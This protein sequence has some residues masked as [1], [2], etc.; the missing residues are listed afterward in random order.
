MMNENVK[1]LISSFGKGLPPQDVKVGTICNYQEGI[2]KAIVEIMENKVEDNY[3][4]IKIKVLESKYMKKDNIFDI[5]VKIGYENLM[6]IWRLTSIGNYDE[7]IPV[8]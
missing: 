5:N 3:V 1:N 4:K 6:G 8:T 2:V 7:N